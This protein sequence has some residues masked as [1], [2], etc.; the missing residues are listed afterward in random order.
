[1][2]ELE[3]LLDLCR[4]RCTDKLR[5]ALKRPNYRQC[6]F[7]PVSNDNDR[8]LHYVCLLGFPDIV[9]VLLEFG[10]D[11]H[12]ENSRGESA[13]TLSAKLPEILELFLSRAGEN[14]D[15]DCIFEIGVDHEEGTKEGEKPARRGY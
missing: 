9:V 2:S 6:L 1:M 8:L 4:R 5:E 11:P 15:E 14:Q 12:Y 3:T 13:V 10:A 7:Q